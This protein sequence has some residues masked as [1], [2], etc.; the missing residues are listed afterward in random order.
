M[1]HPICLKINT[2]WEN[3][4]QNVILQGSVPRPLGDLIEEIQKQCNLLGNCRLQFMD[5]DFDN[6]IMKFVSTS[7]I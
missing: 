2:F 3:S 5:P 7:D 4:S 6:S 1:V